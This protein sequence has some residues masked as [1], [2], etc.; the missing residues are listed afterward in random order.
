DDQRRVS[1]A[2]RELWAL[3]CR[4]ERDLGVHI[5]FTVLSSLT[6]GEGERESAVQRL[7]EA[8]DPHGARVGSLPGVDGNED[9]ATGCFRRGSGLFRWRD[10]QAPRRLAAG[11]ARA[12]LL[13]TVFRDPELRHGCS[14]WRG[15]SACRPQQLR[16]APAASDIQVTVDHGFL[17]SVV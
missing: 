5:S 11:S 15:R 10:G 3:T 13:W 12:V 1:R 14:G 17:A 7:L 9:A 8:D 16:P 6:L 2:E 4:L